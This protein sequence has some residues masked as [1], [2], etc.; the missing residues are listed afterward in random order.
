MHIKHKPGEKMFV[1]YAGKKLSYIDRKSGKSSYRVPGRFSETVIRKEQ[2]AGGKKTHMSSDMVQIGRKYVVGAVSVENRL[3][4]GK[5]C[6]E[7]CR[8]A[9]FWSKVVSRH[10]QEFG[11]S[12]EINNPVERDQYVVKVIEISSFEP[13]MLEIDRVDPL[14]V[15]DMHLPATDRKTVVDDACTATFSGSDI[16]ALRRSR[17]SRRYKS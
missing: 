11:H 1:D 10:P 9:T 13:L 4:A 17:W 2:A 8:R 3:L 5:M 16:Q 14:D 15:F 6:L 12:P 7:D